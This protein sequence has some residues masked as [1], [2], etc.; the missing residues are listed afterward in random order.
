MCR[1]IRLGCSSESGRRDARA[2]PGRRE[3]PRAALAHG[4]DS[5][6]GRCPASARF[7]RPVQERPAQERPVQEG[8]VQETRASRARPPGRRTISAYRVYKLLDDPARP[9]AERATGLSWGSRPG[10]DRTVTGQAR[11]RL[12]RLGILPPRRRL[13]C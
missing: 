9:A 6:T 10:R 2:G 1:E 13:L 3:S 5:D 11:P 7:C 4:A 12:L 8:P